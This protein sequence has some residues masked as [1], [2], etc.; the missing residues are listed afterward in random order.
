MDLLSAQRQ[1]LRRLY[2]WSLQE[3]EAEARADYPLLRSITNPGGSAFLAIVE[4][5]DL[6]QRLAL[7]KVLV[8]NAYFQ[9]PKQ[10]N[11]EGLLGDSF[12]PEEQQLASRYSAMSRRLALSGGLAKP[13]QKECVPTRAK[14]LAKAVT[15]HLS[16]VMQSEFIRW[17]AFTW[18]NAVSI[19]DWDVQTEFYFSGK[20]VE[21]S[22]WLIRRDDPCIVSADIDQQ[23]VRQSILFDYVR[24]LGVSSTWWVVSC[25]QDVPSC[26]DSA[27]LVCERLLRQLSLL[28][29]GLGVYDAEL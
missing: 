23:F 27:G 14:R 8:K 22:H 10:V 18:R 1:L 28:L 7:A 25:E 20:G 19:D 15:Q 3:A 29:Q 4:A 2:Q 9:A 6:N 5:F 13:S 24:R 16:S 11:I 17:E 21:C 12:S 26:L